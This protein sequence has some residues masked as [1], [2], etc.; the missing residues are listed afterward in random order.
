MLLRRL[1]DDGIELFIDYLVDQ[2]RRADLNLQPQHPPTDLL[3]R[4]DTSESIKSSA[5]MNPAPIESRLDA[6]ERISELLSQLEPA[7]KGKLEKDRGFWSWLSLFYFESVCPMVSGKR[8]PGRWDRHVIDPKGRGPYRHLLQAPYTIYS[9]FR[10]SYRD[11][12][13]AL[14]T[15]VSAPGE[16]AEQIT[17]RQHLVSI[18]SVVKAYTELYFDPF[19]GTHKKDAAGR[20][21]GSASRFGVVLNQLDRTF[22]LGSMSANQILDL[23]P[24]EFDRY[25]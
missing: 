5:E 13:A 23:L 7:T 3:H 17:G 4:D 15:A 9:S 21:R 12:M 8:D 10:G 19:K 16:L 2:K 24:S 14:Y 22:D 6:A 18:R 11:A 25:K 1:N 20:R